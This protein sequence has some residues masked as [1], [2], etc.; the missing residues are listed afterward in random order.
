MRRCCRVRRFG[1]KTKIM[2]AKLARLIPVLFAG[3]AASAA[4]AVAPTA[5]AEPPPPPPCVNADGSACSGIGNI[6][7]GGADINIPYGPDGTIDRSGASG[8]IP[9]GPSGSA[10]G[11]SASGGFWNG[12]TGAADRGGASA[13]VPN[14][15]CLSIPAP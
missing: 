14:V 5:Y 9:Y 15:G 4:I 11:G 12:P 13:C 3:A 6:N 2:V 8:G 1:G 10:N 7:A